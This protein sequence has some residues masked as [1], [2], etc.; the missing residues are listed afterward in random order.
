[1]LYGL[2]SCAILNE[3]SEMSLRKCE[4]D[5]TFLCFSRTDA[6]LKFFPQPGSGHMCEGVIVEMELLEAK[7]T[8]ELPPRRKWPEMTEKREAMSCS[9]KSAKPPLKSVQMKKKLEF[10][11]H[12]TLQETFL[13]CSPPANDQPPVEAPEIARFIIFIIKFVPQL[14]NLVI[15]R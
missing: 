4:I 7:S 14:Q 6:W 12:L 8:S 5:K 1:M 9:L 13:T 11:F 10:G 2:G 15:S 3:Y